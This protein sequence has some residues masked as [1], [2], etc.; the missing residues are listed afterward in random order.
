MGRV[1]QVSPTVVARGFPYG[2]TSYPQQIIASGFGNEAPTFVLVTPNDGSAE[3][4]WHY[5]S[6]GDLAQLSNGD[7]SVTIY[8][9]S[10]YTYGEQN[11][12]TFEVCRWGPAEQQICT[13][14]SN[15]EVLQVKDIQVTAIQPSRITV[16][17]AS[18]Q[19]IV[20]RYLLPTYRGPE[21]EDE[22]KAFRAWLRRLDVEEPVIEINDVSPTEED[23]DRLNKGV[24]VRLDAS[25]L[26]HTARYAVE[27]AEDW[28][29]DGYFFDTTGWSSNEVELEIVA[30]PTITTESLPHGWVNQGYSAELVATGGVPDGE[31][32]LYQ[33]SVQSGST[34]P[35][36]LS[37]EV[38]DG[39]SVLTGTPTAA[40]NYEFTLVT[41]DIFGVSDAKTFQVDIFDPVRF[42]STSPLPPATVDEPYSYQFQATG[43]TPPY[44]FFEAMTAD[45]DEIIPG[46]SLMSDGLLTGI[47]TSEGTYTVYVTV[48]DY[49]SYDIGS[50]TLVVQPAIPP[51]T[52]IT[53]AS[54]PVAVTNVPYSV[55]LLTEGGN[56]P[57]Q[58]T[59][60]DPLPNGFT[61]D[62][63]TGVLSGSAA[64]VLDAVFRISVTDSRERSDV[65][66]FQ[67]RVR[68]ELK[69][70]PTS[71]LPPAAVGE[72]YSYQLQA[73]GGTPPYS[74]YEGMTG[75]GSSV[76]GLSLMSNGLLTGVPTTEGTYT[77]HITIRDAD[78][79]FASGE[80]SLVV[81]PDIPPPTFVAEAELPAGRVGANYNLQLLTEGG[82]GPLTFVAEGQLPTGF[83]L[84]PD[85]GVLTGS[86]TEP[87]DT[88]FRI[89]VSDRRGRT[90]SRLF[91]L[92]ILEKFDILTPSPL[93]EGD[94]DTPYT[95]L[96]RTSGGTDPLSFVISSGSLPAGLSL[97]PTT[98]RISGTPTEYGKFAFTI[99]ATEYSG[100][101]ASRAYVLII[102][103]PAN[104]LTLL[105]PSSVPVAFVGQSYS[106]QF[107]AQGG[108]PPYTFEV[109]GNPLPQGLTLNPETGALTGSPT[110][111]FDEEIVI[112]VR[113]AADPQAQDQRSIRLRA[114]QPL[115]FTLL[116][117]PVG[118]VGESYSVQLGAQGGTPSYF[119]TLN[120]GT[121]P[122]GITMNSAGLISGTPTE[123]IES[124]LSVTVTDAESR[125]ATRNFT[126]SI[127]PRPVS[128]STL[129]LSSSLGVANSQNSVFVELSN[130]LE[131]DV[132]GTVTMTVEPQ[133]NPPVEDPAAQFVDGG[134]TIAFTIPA[135]QTRAQFGSASAAT[136]QTGTVAATLR[137]TATFQVG[138]SDAT[139]SPAP[140]ASVAIPVTAP[141]ISDLSVTRNASG[142][143]IVV[144]G[145]SSERVVNTAVLTF[146][147]AAGAPGENPLR[148]EVNVAA[149]FAAWFASEASAPFGSQFRLTLPV[150]FTGDPQDI[151]GVSVQL[152]GPAGTGQ[153]VNASF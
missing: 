5:I 143:Q 53:E 134:R 54:L 118:I 2:E 115:E 24:I 141:S 111:P 82:D 153:A 135:G 126:L 131:E 92:R 90:D 57:L 38:E 86:P 72:Q 16:G 43:G 105:A 59:A 145:F 149:A 17:A 152:V 109:V 144:R 68:H 110:A 124:T 81:Q 13:D 99:Q 3:K 26:D 30:G 31:N 21:G 104:I 146:T 65:R 95:V 128:G 88:T 55:A 37:I 12:V 61:L 83:S 75:D 42:L 113:D 78:E 100:E 70:L 41:T 98:G 116:T 97:N 123:V 148:I 6:E 20:V 51:P 138:G 74:F 130:P 85:T 71:P 96:I 89:V 33:W 32:E 39:I 136:F 107:T 15:S 125:T 46:L 139:P 18:P 133:G 14:A 48:S 69:L 112:R 122:Q 62:P 23:Y 117:L 8:L 151:I 28:W 11:T 45:G 22:P 76:P 77:L 147:R 102:R 79:R 106:V 150:T 132:T 52:F 84:S 119:F 7:W 93:P 67:L 4:Y 103:P 9:G 140:Q 10:V 35:P 56:A 127:R 137:F 25:I 49:G 50:F 120:S 121:L 66:Q 114:L 87:S 142:L 19:D 58:F 80:L 1:S 47:P 108:I 63:T 40:G 64:E 60:L 36:G 27:I 73:S 101:T 34:L 94:V 29:G 91:H 129:N 44:T